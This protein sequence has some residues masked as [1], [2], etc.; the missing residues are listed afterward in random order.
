[1][2]KRSKV[3]Q[4]CWQTP[5]IFSGFVLLSGCGVSR[6]ERWKATSQTPRWGL[7]NDATNCVSNGTAQD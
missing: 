1:M 6:A 2:K 3:S 4:L 7:W 5:R